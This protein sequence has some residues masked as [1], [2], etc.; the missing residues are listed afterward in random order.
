MRASARFKSRRRP[1]LFSAAGCLP[2]TLRKSFG[3][4][5]EPLV[6]SAP[7]FRPGRDL[8]DFSGGLL[9]LPFCGAFLLA[10]ARG[11]LARALLAFRFCAFV[12]RARLLLRGGGRHE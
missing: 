2:G 7:V 3:C 12:R 10:F 11:N 1:Q 8:V 9:V 6:A 4:S 5:L